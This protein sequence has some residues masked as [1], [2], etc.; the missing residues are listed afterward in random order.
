MRAY[1]LQGRG[2]DSLAIVERPSPE[3]GPGQVRVRIRAGSLNYR[4]LLIARGAYGRG[5]PKLPLVPPASRS[6]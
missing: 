2:I 1:E 6:P 5:A 4:D 3:P